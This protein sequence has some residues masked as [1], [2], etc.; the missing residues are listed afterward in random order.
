MNLEVRHPAGQRYLPKGYKWYLSSRFRW[1]SGADH[2]TWERFL[3]GNLPFFQPKHF[4]GLGI[5]WRWNGPAPGD[6]LTMIGVSDAWTIA[7]FAALPIG[8][9]AVKPIGILRR[10]HRSRTSRCTMCSYQLTG[11][12]SGVCPECGTPVLVHVGS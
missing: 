5:I 1:V 4:A 8:R 12:T 10:R 9:I 2:L 11:N 3:Q 7:L 6:E